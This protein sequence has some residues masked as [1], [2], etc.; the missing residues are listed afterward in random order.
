MT[1]GG[2]SATWK[3]RV[4][5]HERVAPDAIKPH[6]Q[7]WRL[8]SAEQRAAFRSIMG[9]VGFVGS[10]VANKR[11]G[12]ILDG[13]LRHEEAVAGNEPLVDV[14]WVDLAPEEEA[15]VLASFDPLGAMAGR[16]DAMLNEL[17]GSMDSDMAALMRSLVEQDANGSGRDEAEHSTLAEKFVVPPFTI[18]D[19]RQGYWQARKRSWVALGIKS[20]VGRGANLLKFSDTV[21]QPDPDKRKP[22]GPGR[23]SGSKKSAY[24]A[25]GMGDMVA[26]AGE[27]ADQDFD[28]TSIFDPVLCELVYRWFSGKGMRVLDPFA[29]GSV[30]GIVAGYLGRVYDGLDLRAE[31]VKAN[32]QQYESLPD[33]VALKMAAPTWYVQDSTNLDEF[34]DAEYKADLVF[35]CPP[36]GDLE[37]YSDDNR[38]LSNMDFDEFSRMY[39][40]VIR[41]ACARL[42]DNRFA[43]FVVGDYRDDRGFYT[44]FIALT[45]EAFR[46]A[47]LQLYNEA[48]LVGAVGSLPIRAG[49]Q[50]TASRKLGKC[51]Q[52]VLV[53]VKGDPVK[54]TRACG[55]VDVEFG[56]EPAAPDIGGEV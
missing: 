53:F 43:C 32:V 38:D 5:G 20:E 52:N 10:I 18:L 41:A 45:I 31:Q 56:L 48:I 3:S 39:A 12:F 37:Q 14:L 35:S 29:G 21:L 40:R 28:G 1:S 33:E 16:D 47:G 11:T 7:N 25:P 42:N 51:H 54:A 34:F 46:A 55:E 17:L 44:G 24:A 22:L 27:E 30:R 8:H 13:H 2:H 4:L 6:P 15:V 50:F 49:K 26:R 36:Y 19:T 23:H 9:A